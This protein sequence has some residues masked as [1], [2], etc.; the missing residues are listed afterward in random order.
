MKSTT[1]RNRGKR[2]VPLAPT[3]GKARW[4]PCDN[5]RAQT[6]ADRRAVA[7]KRACR[8]KMSQDFS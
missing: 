7:D 5:T 4:N 8:G 2:S 1:R 3:A 6:F